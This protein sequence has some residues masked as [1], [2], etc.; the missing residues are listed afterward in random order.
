MNFRKIHLLSIILA[1]LSSLLVPT[2]GFNLTESQSLTKKCH[3]SCGICPIN[4]PTTCSY[5]NDGYFHHSS[6]R[7]SF[8][9]SSPNTFLDF[10]DQDCKSCS[11]SCNF[12]IESASNCNDCEKN[13]YYRPDTDSC[14]P[15]C[16]ADSG[17]YQSVAERRCI[18]CRDPNCLSCNAMGECLKCRSFWHLEV[19][20]G[21]CVTLCPQGCKT[22]SQSNSSCDECEVDWK[23]YQQNFSEITTINICQCPYENCLQCGVSA[24]VT[25]RDGFFKNEFN[26]CTRCT[27]GCQQCSSIQSCESCSPGYF[28]SEGKC[29]P[30]P[31]GCRYC[32]SEDDCTSCENGY[33]MERARPNRTCLPRSIVTKIRT[34]SPLAEDERSFESDKE[35]SAVSHGRLYYSVHFKASSKGS[36]RSSSS[37]SSHSSSSSSSSHSSSSSGSSSSSS[38]STP[39]SAPKASAP[40]APSAHPAST[41]S[42]SAHSTQKP[43]ATS[44]ASASHYP[45]STSTS[46]STSTTSATSTSGTSSTSRTN[47]SNPN[48]P[49]YTGGYGTPYQS[50]TGSSFGSIIG[51]LIMLCM[52]CCCCCWLIPMFMKQN[53]GPSLLQE[54]LNSFELQNRN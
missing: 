12:C 30:C 11:S 6:D 43:S 29:Q 16:P 19:T 27:P 1:V 9:C 17:F 38:K 35:I 34:D 4:Q 18:P 20:T 32:V 23:N 49:Y 25:C 22:C 10:N 37:T 47:T 42:A 40:S 48:D 54:P 41:A 7:C 45:K 21:R 2:A 15:N 13:S 39:V 8:T 28:K 26:E 52:C 46:T 50:P 5:C 44:S 53:S 3:V 51:V 36:S 33:Y 31:D 14:A 24:C